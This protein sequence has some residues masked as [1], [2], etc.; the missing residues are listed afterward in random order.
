[1]KFYGRREELKRLAEISKQARATG[2]LTMI[3][4]RRRDGKTTLVKHFL[5]QRNLPSCYFFI[6]RT[7]ITT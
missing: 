7:I 1:M 6:P 4:G 2:Y 5:Q 3:T